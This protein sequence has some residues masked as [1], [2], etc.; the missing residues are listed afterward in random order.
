M[1]YLAFGPAQHGLSLIGL[2]LGC[3]CNPWAGSAWHV[4]RA[5]LA[6]LTSART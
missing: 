6:K 2:C 1:G 5:G 3:L 4:G